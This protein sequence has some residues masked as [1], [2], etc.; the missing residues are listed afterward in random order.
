MIILGIVFIIIIIIIII[1]TCRP[2]CAPGSPA[3]LLQATRQ[4]CVVPALADGILENCNNWQD[5]QNCAAD[6][7]SAS[8]QSH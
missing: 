2:T 1:H 6:Y 7:S 4:T 5:P 3:I 8:L